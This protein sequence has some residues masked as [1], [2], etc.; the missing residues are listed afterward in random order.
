MQN[1][2][3]G[4][5]AERLA[6]HLIRQIPRFEGQ[7]SVEVLNLAKN[8]LEIGHIVPED[9]YLILGGS[10]ARGEPCFFIRDSVVHILSDLDFLIVH[11]SPLP[12]IGEEQFLTHVTPSLPWS[13][14]YTLRE[15]QYQVLGTSL[16]Q[17]FKRN[18]ICLNKLGLPP[19][20]SIELTSRDAFEI[21]LF[22]I[23]DAYRHG[24][25]RRCA[26]G[27]QTHEL[28][29]LVCRTEL[30]CLRSVAMLYGAYNYHD[31]SGLPLNL[32]NRI[33]PLLV[34]RDN[35]LETSIPTLS[36]LYSTFAF[37][38]QCFHEHGKIQANA[39]AGSC[40][41]SRFGSQFVAFLQSLALNLLKSI[42]DRITFNTPDERIVSLENA[43]WKELLQKNHH[44]HST[45]TPEEYFAS[46]MACF[47][48]LLLALKVV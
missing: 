44:V 13:T 29:Y 31:I 16:G 46:Q 11:N 9:A 12:P 27:E 7:P 26:L 20:K 10:F 1:G 4:W 18:A 39:I 22:A 24:I 3:S 32:V 17:D 35:P 38:L 36:Q 34:W 47:R 33:K 14:V 37:A 43:S 42:L 41:T 23:I 30:N 6:R 5:S 28:S 45:D 48:Y 2:I 19:F 15:Q 25:S 21:F 8:L 40:Y